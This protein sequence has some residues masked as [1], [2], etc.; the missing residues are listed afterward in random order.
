MTSNEIRQS[1]FDFF[2]EKGHAIVP[3]SPVVPSDDPTLLF[4]NAGMAPFKP[5]FLG[6]QAG[7]MV[8]G[9]EFRRVAD[10]QKCIRVSGKH[11]D[12]E[13]VGI[14]TY[15]HTLFEM[16]GNWSFGDY[17][18]EEAIEWAWELLVDRWGL[19]P[20]RLYATVF[21]GDDQDGVPPDTEAEELWASKTSIARD[22]ILR[23]GK[24][25]NFWEMG[26]TG[27][28][29][30]CSEIHIDLRSDEE[31]AKT[32]GSSL[33]NADDPRVMEIWNLVFIQFDRQKNGSLKPLPDKHVDTGMG[34]ERICAVLQGKTSNY[35]SDVFEGLIQAIAKDAGVTYGQEE[36]TDIAIR[37]IADHI[38]AVAFAAGD[39]AMPS[40]EG[41]GYVIRRI[42]R[43]AVRYG[44]DRLGYTEP[45]MHRFVDP[46]AA[47]FKDVFPEL[48]AQK[49]SLQD[50]IR[51][52]EASF[53]KTLGQGIERFQ[54]LTKGQNKVSGEAAFMLHD[55]YGFPVD[56]TSL[57][58]REQ[59]LEVDL[60]GF[61]ALMAQQK[62]RARAAGA[63][64]TASA[65]DA[66]AWQLNPEASV[67][68]LD[69]LGEAFDF[70]GYDHFESEVQLVAKATLST[71][72]G[73][74][75][76]VLLDRSPFYAESGGQTAD[77]GVLESP[78]ETLNVLDVQ[79]GRHGFVHTVDRL[80]TSFSGPWTA[81]VDRVRR[82]ETAKHHS[83][84][85]LLH[86]ILRDTLGSHV[87]QKG[88]LVTHDRMRFDFAHFEQIP[89]ETL[90]DI[91]Q[92]VN[93]RIQENIPLTEERD[94]SIDQAKERG[95]M[96]LF[97]EKYGES[98]RIITFDPEFSVELC[99]GTH[100]QA[101]GDL[102]LYV[103]T[104]ESSAS[105]G[106]RRIEALTGSAALS[107]VQ[108]QLQSL[109]DAQRLV[110]GGA[111]NLGESIQQLQ[112]AKKDLETQ[113]QSISQKQLLGQLPELMDQA[114][115][116]D[117]A[118]HL[119]A[120]KVPGASMDGLKQMGYEALRQK[121][122]GLA[123]VLVSHDP[124]QGKVAL[125]A[126]MTD[127]VIQRGGHAGTWVKGLAALVGGGGGGQPNLA[128]AGGKNPDGMDELVAKA[129]DQLKELL[130]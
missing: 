98:V 49:S 96:M 6:Q 90:A 75:H 110:G 84:A 100:V 86:A 48:E 46:L 36:S 8:Q 123:I 13:E 109:S 43:R 14:D 108:R 120:S 103:I 19:D 54:E 27:P 3:S 101:T 31:R 113:L 1:F 114:I 28:S 78:T 128:T 45:F 72:K 60:D 73:D 94:V 88:S 23:C 51:A 106:V 81:K 7:L 126:A 92:Q 95:A 116:L 33:V 111:S 80:P 122:T 29:G 53:I 70:I 2:A 10:T 65:N 32:P 5:I 89:Q 22:H 99:A 85:H 12:L 121:P 112:E 16:L 83:S 62:E 42:L 115:V 4:I 35:D 129:G 77:H 127:D 25:D 124:E 9:K 97:G 61:D 41:R 117:N 24:K 69:A 82:T 93:L 20:D 58:A 87:V 59:G 64:A 68:T 67:K 76:L 39:G 118:L 11:N 17:F 71:K 102:G 125:M 104:S 37:V 66:T 21:G 50:I 40:N 18:K 107:Y 38:R 52:E 55:T 44:W 79:K 63:T 47:Q 57:M 30:P 56:L 130:G 26:E 105:A 74:K 15:H 34:F 119:I 91:Q